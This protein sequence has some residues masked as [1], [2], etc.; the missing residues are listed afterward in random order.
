MN[1][2]AKN[3]KEIVFRKLIKSDFK[4]LAHYLQNLSEESKSRFGPHLYDLEAVTTFYKEN[5]NIGIVGIETNNKNIVAYSIIKQGFILADS[6]RYK[7]YKLP[8][9]M[10][11]DFTYAPSVA[12]NWQSLGLGDAMFK[13][14][15]N[16]IQTTDC[17]RII[18]WGG[19]QK[20]NEKAVN[21]YQKNGF[22][23]HGQFNNGNDNWDMALNIN[24]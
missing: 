15:K 12:D 4:S 18:L 1:F 16:I 8:L 23:T 2:I 19:V 17:K 7:T 10:L 22:I 6:E 9:S 5:L 24:N 14:M 21:Y 3:H 20:T 13:Y 11:T